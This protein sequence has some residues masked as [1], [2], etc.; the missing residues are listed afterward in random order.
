VSPR[1]ERTRKTSK[2][3]L[4]AGLLGVS[5]AAH[6]R[7]AATPLSSD[8][9]C[10]VLEKFGGQVQVLDPA[11]TQLIDAT[12]ETGIPCSGWVSIGR[13]WARI[14]HRDGYRFYAG[15]GTFIQIPEGG[16]DPDAPFDQ[17][18]LFRGQL[19]GQAGEGSRELRVLTANAR[20]RIRR[21]TSVVI[22]NQEDQE[23]QLVALEY[24][25]TLENR[26]QDSRR[27][28]VNAGEA[29]SLDFRA[30]R[31]VPTTPRAVAISSLRQ[32]L[33]DLHV[34]ERDKKSAV[35]AAQKRQDRKFA[36]VI[37]T[38]APEPRLIDRLP[39]G[40]D[41]APEER[42]GGEGGAPGA[43]VEAASASASAGHAGGTR[44]KRKPAS[45][46]SDEKQ[47]TYNRHLPSR[48]DAALREHWARKLV[49]GQEAGEKILNPEKFY[50][51]PQQVKLHVEDAAGKRKSRARDEDAERARLLHEL[52]QIRPD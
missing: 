40:P 43:S 38:A 34:G 46:G 19:Y 37:A 31:V 17:V 10:S 1:R 7:E 11:R 22:Y 25:S 21:G 44:A 51:R 6:A 41:A 33:A 20:A 48:E 2:A 9:P 13:G 3:L 32:K 14:R 49:A 12:A 52:S 27:I 35:R 42:E 28:K 30:L 26:F 36:S 24:S 50:G 29:T 47:H 8:V 4:L 39:G 5:A 23:T 15:S 16:S 18:I 45:Q